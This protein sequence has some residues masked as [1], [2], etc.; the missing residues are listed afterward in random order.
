MN[1][2]DS[3][4]EDRKF[5]CLKAKK[6]L[7]CAIEMALRSWS[8]VLFDFYLVI[9]R[10]G[11]SDDPLLNFLATALRF[12]PLLTFSKTP[13]HGGKLRQNLKRRVTR[14][15]NYDVLTRRPGTTVRPMIQ[16]YI[17]NTYYQ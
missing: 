4:T 15:D 6:C 7:P 13:P 10:V 16:K 5:R 1:N 14:H 9:Q 3:K 12:A 2:T 17:D 8:I 11:K